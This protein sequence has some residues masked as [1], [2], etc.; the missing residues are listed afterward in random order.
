M[1]KT[2]INVVITLFLA[3]S[4]MS[5]AFEGHIKFSDSYIDYSKLNFN[6]L[7]SVGNEFLL[8]AENSSDKSIQK[9]YYSKALL[10]YNVASKVQ[11]ENIIP[12]IRLGQIYGKTAQFDLAQK[13][14]FI[15][16]NLEA[17]NPEANYYFGN[18]YFDEQMYRKALKYYLLAFKNG[19]ET[20]FDTNLKLALVYEKL[21]DLESAKKYY[22]NAFLIKPADKRL[23]NKIHLSDDT[24]YRNSGYYLFKRKM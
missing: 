10:Y 18:F 2:F 24:N 20:D 15:A 9:E 1:K 11:P 23:R 14:F 17:K 6:E 5:Y 19:Y 3:I 21:A 7:N 12:F 22:K 13:N 4:S 16:T 8:S